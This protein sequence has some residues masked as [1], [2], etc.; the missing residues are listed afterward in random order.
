M[1]LVCSNCGHYEK[2]V[3]KGYRFGEEKRERRKPGVAIID[4]KAKRKIEMINY[5]IDTD[6]YLELYE[7]Y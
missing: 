4:E 5:D 3:E 2:L 6:E 1:W 7:E